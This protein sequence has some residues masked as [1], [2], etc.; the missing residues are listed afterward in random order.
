M[1]HRETYEPPPPL[2]VRRAV[3]GGL[4]A[5][6]AV[7]VLLLLVR[8][9]IFSLAPPRGDT[10]LGI[11]SFDELVVGPISRPVLLT[12]SHGLLG[13]RVEGERIAITVIIAPLPG[14]AVA[15]LNAWSTVDPCPVTVADDARSLTDCDGRRWALDGAPLDGG[16]QPPLQRFAATLNNG[17]VIADLSAP[18]SGPGS[19]P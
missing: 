2:P 18:V 11:A 15:V 9:A 1:T 14:S 7:M 4:L 5:F 12:A 19:V 13:E 3:V 10:N 16:A 6:G 17:A 8:P